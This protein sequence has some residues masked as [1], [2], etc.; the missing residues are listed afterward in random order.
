MNPLTDATLPL[1][2]R[3]GCREVARPQSRREWFLWTDRISKSRVV[4]GNYLIWTWSPRWCKTIFLH[5]CTWLAFIVVSKCHRF[6]NQGPI[7]SN[8]TKRVDHTKGFVN[9]QSYEGSFWDWYGPLTNTLCKGTNAHKSFRES[10]PAP[11]RHLRLQRTHSFL[12]VATAD[13]SRWSLKL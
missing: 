13:R 4:F 12:F 1:R 9:G 2:A 8:F 7:S 5:T 10:A 3:K 11:K 6:G